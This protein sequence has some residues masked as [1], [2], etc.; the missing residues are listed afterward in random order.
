[1]KK[2]ILSI[3]FVAALLFSSGLLSSVEKSEAKDKAAIVG[4]SWTVGHWDYFGPNHTP[5]LDCDGNG[6]IL[7]QY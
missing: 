1:M 2:Q 7:C 4:D 3:T 5:F 6:I